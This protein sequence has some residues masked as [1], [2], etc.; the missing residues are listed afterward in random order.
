MIEK[1][2][3]RIYRAGKKDNIY[4]LKSKQGLKAI[5]TIKSPFGVY[6]STNFSVEQN[7]LKLNTLI[8]NEKL[9]LN[10]KF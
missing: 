6:H 10:S 8:K 5:E 7:K 9:F 3:K 1:T 4:Q 2:I